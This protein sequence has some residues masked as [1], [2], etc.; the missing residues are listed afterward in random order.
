MVIGT[1]GHSQSRENP[2]IRQL[3][4]CLLLALSITACSMQPR[5]Q[6]TQIEIADQTFVTLPQPS[7]LG[8]DVTASQL[9]TATWQTDTGTQTQQLPVQLQVDQNKLVLAG[10]SSWGTRLLSLT[11][12]DN[13]IETQVLNGLENTLPQPEQVLFNLMIT[14]WPEQA[15]EAPLNQVK[16]QL[17]DRDNQRT[18]IDNHGNT[19]IVIDYEQGRS[20]AGPIR[21][22]SLLNDYK[23]EIQTLNYQLSDAK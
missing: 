3:L 20:F 9:I 2:M 23:I 17:I 12:Q 11:Y 13:H 21:F 14:L 10:F 22:H 19:I 16:W 5:T 15:W 6:S 18:I 1:D 4:L 7:E 8:L